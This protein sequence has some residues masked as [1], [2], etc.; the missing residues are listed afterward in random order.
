[1]KHQD[2]DPSL[3]AAEPLLD[4]LADGFSPPVDAQPLQPQDHEAQPVE[5]V[6]SPKSPF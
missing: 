1:M 5:T 3:R 6:L 2:I 4:S